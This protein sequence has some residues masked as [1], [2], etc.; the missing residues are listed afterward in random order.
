MNFHYLQAIPVD[1]TPREESIILQHVADIA[2]GSTERLVLI[3][4]ELHSSSLGDHA[5]QAP[6]IARQVHRVV[7]MLTRSQLLLLA[8]VSAYC[9]WSPVDCLVF[10]NQG[11]WPQQEQGP[12]RILH[13]MYLRIVIPPPPQAAWEIGFTLRTFQDAAE[14]FDQPEAGRV[15]VEILQRNFPS[16][17]VSGS[18]GPA[19]TIPVTSCK[20]ADLGPYDIDVPTMHAPS[21][22]HR[23]LRPPHD[24][25]LQWLLDLGQIFAT[26]AEDE[27]FVDE[28]LLYVQTWFINHET[29]MACRD[30]RPLRLERQSVTWIDDF[31]HLWHD[32]LNRRQPFSLRVVRPTPPQPRSQHYA[33][34]VLVEQASRPTR[35]AVVLTALLEGDRRDGFIQGAFSIPSMVR[36]QDIVDIMEIEPFCDGRRCTMHMDDIP[37]HLIAATEVPS[38]RSIRIRIFDPSSQRP[39]PPDSDMPHFEDLVFL[40]MSSVIGSRTHGVD[41]PPETSSATVRNAAV[42]ACVPVLLVSA[43]MREMFMVSLA[44]YKTSG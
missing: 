24:G 14:M 15:A 43:P 13:G 4:I 22:Y 3:D 35:S 16:P 6:R 23:R 42:S 27:A 30:P 38:G 34:H 32:R 8:R 18:P 25:T 31:R 2:P 29:F 41:L 11:L 19:D 40:Q 17:D 36:H 33:C 7:P 1:Q 28:P 10:C 39:V 20:G 12:R 26:S 44:T 37:L 5:T 9:E 21:A